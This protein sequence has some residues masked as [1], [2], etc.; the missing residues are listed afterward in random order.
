M[1][2]AVPTAV[3]VAKRQLTRLIKSPPLLLPAVLFPLL[4]FT[5]FAGGLSALGT[6]PNFG[7]PD[8]TTFQFMWV[9][10]VATGVSGAQTGL[11]VAEDLESGFARRM[12]LATR[13]RLPLLAGYALTA[14]VRALVVVALLFAIG[15]IAGMEVSGTPIQVAAVVVLGM[16]FAIITAMWGAGVALRTGRVQTAGPAIQ[17]P[18]VIVAFLTPVYTPR[19]L[20]ADW[21]KAIA[22]WNPV[23]AILEA[24]RGLLVDHPVSV[25]LAF[26]V[27]AAAI[28]VFSLW[29]V[30]G[31]RSAEAGGA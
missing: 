24:G 31:L 22:D 9:L 15:L 28:V 19:Q 5:A 10:V 2:E 12:M 21:V 1:S 3:G 4:L 18:I 16:M 25:A 8:Y 14:V 26:G 13:T 29:A 23:T 6:A 7:Y 17:T 11:A 20:L 30:T 27:A